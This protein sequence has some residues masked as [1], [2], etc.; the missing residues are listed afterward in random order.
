MLAAA[1]QPQGGGVKVLARE[2]TPGV[3][4]RAYGYRQGEFDGSVGRNELDFRG[5]CGN[6]RSGKRR[7]RNRVHGH[8]SVT[9]WRE[10]H[11]QR[12]ASDSNSPTF[13]ARSG[14]AEK[15]SLCFD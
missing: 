8:S 2:D 13:G 6:A 15:N 5:E 3:L 7:S 4:R 1:V 9:R 11:G 10:R 14:T 12:N